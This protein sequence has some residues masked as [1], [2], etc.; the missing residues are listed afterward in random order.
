MD[1]LDA[2]KVST[3]NINIKFLI[4]VVHILQANFPERLYKV[5]IANTNWFI[6]TVW[7]SVRPFLKEITR[8]KVFFRN[9]KFFKIIKSSILLGVLKRK[10]SKLSQKRWKKL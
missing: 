1:I 3:A 8:K 5:F 2:G 10:F 9:F 6:K 7:Q 4:D